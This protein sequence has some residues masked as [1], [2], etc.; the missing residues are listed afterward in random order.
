MQTANILLTFGD[1]GMS[2]RLI[3]DQIL[4]RCESVSE[5]YVPCDGMYSCLWP[6]DCWNLKVL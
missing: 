1:E 5:W 4:L 6:D 3:G 2:I